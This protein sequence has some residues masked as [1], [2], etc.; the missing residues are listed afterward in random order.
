MER[1]VSTWISWIKKTAVVT[2]ILLS[3]FLVIRFPAFASGTEAAAHIDLKDG[4]YSVDVTLGGGSGR[5]SVVSPAALTVKDGTA[6][7][8]IAWSSPNY[9]YMKIGNE[10]YD[11]VNTEGN[12]V[13]E[14]PVSAFDEEIPV[15]A[16]TTAMSVPHEISYTLTFHLDSVRKGKGETVP[17][18]LVTAVCLV[19][20]AAGI[21]FIWRTFI[22]GKK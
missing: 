2:G 11:P 1:R 10:I 13:F 6:C 17:K 16:D 7:A 12:S 21:L 15:A 4:E 20:G 22:K 9:D 3:A 8:R 5:A 19:V 18:V 14:I